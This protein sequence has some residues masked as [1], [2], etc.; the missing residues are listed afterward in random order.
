MTFLLAGGKFFLRLEFHQKRKLEKV[1]RE[2]GIRETK[3]AP[4]S[5]RTSEQTLPKRK[6]DWA[7]NPC[8][9]L[10]E[11]VV[12]LQGKNRLL[13]LPSKQVGGSML[14]TWEVTCVPGAERQKSATLGNDGFSATTF[15]GAVD[16]RSGAGTI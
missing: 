6:A 16:A 13:F 1:T 8:L 9:E 3:V 14:L 15:G 12:T 7:D 10:S 11:V 4:G 2:G 5:L